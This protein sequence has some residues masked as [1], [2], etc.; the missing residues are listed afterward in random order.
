VRGLVEAART[1][2][3]LIERLFRENCALRRENDRLARYRR[4]ACVDALTGLS[5]RRGF[6]ERIAAEL[7]RAARTGA[8]LSLVYM[9]LDDF[10]LLNDGAG[11]LAGDRALEWV[12]R[13]LEDTI[14][15]SDVACRIG[16]DE[17]AVILPDTDPTGAVLTM[18]RIRDTLAAHPAAPI[19]PD[20]RPLGISQGAATCPDDGTTMAAL[21]ARADLRMF[22]DKAA[23]R[24]A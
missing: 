2:R 19:L 9:D 6:D 23:K 16:G 18:D 17:F 21:L 11:H 20:G 7:S 5:N 15:T 14:R 10:K 4:L 13:F 1:D 8:P 22:D 12:G 3:A 24:A